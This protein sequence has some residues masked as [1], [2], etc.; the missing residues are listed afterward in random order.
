MGS[1][2]SGPGR[3]L[4]PQWL[5]HRAVGRIGFA[6]SKHKRY[7]LD[8]DLFFRFP[9][10]GSGVEGDSLFRRLMGDVLRRAANI[11]G[12]AVGDVL[13]LDKPG[14]GQDPLHIPLEQRALLLVHEHR[15][16]HQVS[17]I[18]DVIA[19]DVP[20]LGL[21]D[22]VGRVDPGAKAG[23]FRG[24]LI[25]EPADIRNRP[26]VEYMRGP[27]PPIHKMPLRAISVPVIGDVFNRPGIS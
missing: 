18:R 2:W 4:D 8:L 20:N 9:E 3:D 15:V 5:L 6:V 12:M 7:G 27:H 26:P 10:A 23:A 22:F 1:S 25:L 11:S 19:V 16:P 14:I 24:L 13:D 17:P 21:N